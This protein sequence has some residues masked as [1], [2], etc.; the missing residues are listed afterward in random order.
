MA[1]PNYCMRKTKKKTREIPS[2]RRRRKHEKEPI[3]ILLIPAADTMYIY[4]PH[5]DGKPI[6][7][8]FVVWPMRK[9]HSHTKK[10]NVKC[11]KNVAKHTYYAK[12][13][14]FRELLSR[15]ARLQW[16][17]TVWKE[18]GVAKGPRE[19]QNAAICMD[20][21]NEFRIGCAQS[22]R[23]TA[24]HVQ[25]KSRIETFSTVPNRCNVQFWFG[26]YREK[27]TKMYKTA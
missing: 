6:T 26:G 1:A 12:P 21:V 24:E 4:D 11:I 7:F 10:N 3:L 16:Y 19:T 23:R 9:M 8:G 20:D 18:I 13:S 22:C 15:T 25:R 14:I 5:G 2:R 17:A 27:K